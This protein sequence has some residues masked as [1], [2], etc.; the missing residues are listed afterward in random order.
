MIRSEVPPVAVYA[1]LLLTLMA[2]LSASLL[3]WDVARKKQPAPAYQLP[4]QVNP[5]Q[6]D[7][8]LLVCLPG[9]GP[10]RAQAIIAYRCE[11]HKQDPRTPAFAS[12]QDLTAVKGIG[13]GIVNQMAPYLCFNDTIYPSQ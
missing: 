10:Y 8:S 5:N 1:F 2:W 6:A 7:L 12:L 4:Q 13:P 9:L 3:V 11:S